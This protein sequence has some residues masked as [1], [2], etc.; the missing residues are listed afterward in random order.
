MGGRKRFRIR[1]REGGTESE[2]EE[3]RSSS[4]KQLLNEI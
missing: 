1:E 3:G 4:T 2:K